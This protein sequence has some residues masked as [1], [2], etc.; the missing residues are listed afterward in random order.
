MVRVEVV[1]LLEREVGELLLEVREV[2]DNQCRNKVVS[3]LP[4]RES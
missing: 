1:E 3:H 2:V 4:H